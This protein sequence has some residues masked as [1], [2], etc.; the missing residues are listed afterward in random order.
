MINTLKYNNDHKER[1]QSYTMYL[2]LDWDLDLESPAYCSTKE[3]A[4]FELI[5]NLLNF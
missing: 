5:E 4:Y 3:D 2:S 1:S